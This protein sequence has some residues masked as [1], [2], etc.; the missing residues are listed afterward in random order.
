VT[1]QFLN[2][3]KKKVNPYMKAPILEKAIERYGIENNRVYTLIMDELG[4]YIE[5]VN[6]RILNRTEEDTIDPLKNINVDDLVGNQP[7]RLLLLKEQAK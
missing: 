6:S 5:N 7:T 1:L 2:A 4:R 3:P